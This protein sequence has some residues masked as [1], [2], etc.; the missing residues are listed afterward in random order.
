M[1]A[2]KSRKIVGQ[3]SAWRAVG[4]GFTLGDAFARRPCIVKRAS[5]HG[6]R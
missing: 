6:G 3:V 2:P 5:R 4:A 1:D